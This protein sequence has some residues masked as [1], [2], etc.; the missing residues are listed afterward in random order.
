MSFGSYYVKNTLIRLVDGTIK[1]CWTNLHLKSKFVH[2][3]QKK[4]LFVILRE[5]AKKLIGMAQKFP[6]VVLLGPR[7]SGKTTFVRTTF[8]NYTY[9]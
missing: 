2:K 1:P 4:G 9:I 3:I 5:L 7:Q 6:V 8:E